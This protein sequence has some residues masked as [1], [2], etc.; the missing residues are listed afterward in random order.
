MRWWATYDLSRASSW[1]AGLT[2]LHVSQPRSGR[3][4]ALLANGNF[5]SATSQ[6][7]LTTLEGL[8]ERRALDVDAIGQRQLHEYQGHEHENI[9]WR[10]GDVG[11][12]YVFL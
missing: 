5:A 6:A 1:L 7:G 12:R 10:C 2:E 3:S 9:G 11:A 4:V 8:Q